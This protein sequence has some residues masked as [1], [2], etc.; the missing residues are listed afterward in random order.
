[1]ERNECRCVRIPCEMFVLLPI[2]ILLSPTSSENTS[3]LWSQCANTATPSTDAQCAVALQPHGGTRLSIAA[4]QAVLDVKSA[5]GK[6]PTTRLNASIN[7]LSTQSR[8]RLNALALEKEHALTS[9]LVSAI[10]TNLSI[11]TTA[12]KCVADSP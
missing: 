3:L 10:T 4:P 6:Y 7:S 5:A 1:M 12:L 2:L 11:L 8:Q 9:T